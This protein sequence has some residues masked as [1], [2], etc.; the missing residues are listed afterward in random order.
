MASNSN[1]KLHKNTKSSPAMQQIKDYKCTRRAES[2]K[3]FPAETKLVSFRGI[4]SV[5]TEKHQ[6]DVLNDF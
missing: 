3:D 5:S 4:Y 1:K 6:E 2:L